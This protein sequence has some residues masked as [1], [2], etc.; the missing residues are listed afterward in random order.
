MPCAIYRLRSKEH[1]V[2]QQS[3]HYVVA[4]AELRRRLGTEWG[5]VVARHMH[6]ND[7]FSIVAMDGRTPAGVISVYWRRLPPPLPESY[8]GYIDIIE[9]HPDYRRRGVARGLV[10]MAL[11]RGKKQGVHQLRAWSSE[12]KVEAIPMWQAL[13][14]G[15]CPATTY[16]GGEEVRGY[17][18]TK[19]IE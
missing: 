12:D 9:V 14:F 18:V 4:D 6:L 15:L 7:G 5:E 2:T 19:L 3:L 13:G 11:K 10:E 8:E 17:F 1:T 16:P